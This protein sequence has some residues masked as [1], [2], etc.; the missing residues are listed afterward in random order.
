MVL[1]MKE[2]QRL[3][4]TKFFKFLFLNKFTIVQKGCNV[5]QKGSLHVCGCLNPEESTELCVCRET[6]VR[7]QEACQG[8]NL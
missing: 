2:P 1:E 5:V 6:G 4:K 8:I 7:G 3:E